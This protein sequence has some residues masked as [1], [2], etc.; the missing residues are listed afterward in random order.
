[1]K[2]VGFANFIALM[3]DRDFWYFLYNTVFFMIGIPIGMAVSLLFAVLVNQ[4]LRGIVFFRTIYFLPVI[5]SLIAVAIVWRWIFNSEYGLLNNL[6]L[7]LGFTDV[8]NWLNST[9]WAKP[10]L[11][12][13]GVWQGAGYN[14]LLYLAALQGIPDSLYEAAS[15]DGASAWQRFR[16]ITWPSLSFVNFFVVTMSIISG[17]QAF[18]GQYIMT[19]GGPLNSTMTIVYYIYNNAFKWFRMGY[20]SAI[21]WF[22]FLMMFAVTYVNLRLRKSWDYSV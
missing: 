4:K 17:F 21:A 20:A 15:I 11:I 9:F 5:S 6:L 2:F 13:M 1:M 22:L 12:I 7:T 3:K 8:P 19:Q 10:A 18:G 16:Y 14:M